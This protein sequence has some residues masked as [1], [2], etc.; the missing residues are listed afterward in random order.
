MNYGKH[1]KIAETVEELKEENR[2]LKDMLWPYAREVEDLNTLEDFYIEA[3]RSMR[4]RMPKE[5]FQE[6]IH[7][8][9]EKAEHMENSA[10]EAQFFEVLRNKFKCGIGEFYTGAEYEF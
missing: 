6:A 5:K 7:E 2:L 10:A 3:L 4:R 9:Y 1:Y 8:A